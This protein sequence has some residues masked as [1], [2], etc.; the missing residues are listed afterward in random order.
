MFSKLEFSDLYK[1]L[2]SVGLIFIALSLLLPWLVMNQGDTL[3]FS[4]EDYDQLYQK[5]ANL[6]DKRVEFNLLA[7]QWVP[8]ISIV[9]FSLGVLLV[10][11]GIAKW[12]P[13]QRKVDETEAIELAKLQLSMTTLD[14][15]AIHKKAE[16]EV[17]MEIKQSKGNDT[18]EVEVEEVDSLEKVRRVKEPTASYAPK[19]L[20][21]FIKER[22]EQ[23]DKLIEMEQLF[24]NKIIEYNSFNYKPSSNVQINSKY[25]VDI[26]LN[27]HNIRDN[28][29]IIIEIK[30]LQNQLSM[31][32]VRDEAKRLREL[33]GQYFSLTKRRVK[34]AIVIVYKHD[35]ANKDQI[36]RF[37]S[38]ISDFT[39]ELNAAIMQLYVLSDKETEQFDIRSIVQ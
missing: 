21:E 3:A 31:S 25:E 1:F 12:L 5:S 33:H 6:L 10:W 32:T 23:R 38:A 11:L 35:I 27:S 30:Y 29:D 8:L 4:Q 16:K 20:K 28:S 34:I 26:L 18:E 39:N 9:M 37:R 19:S 15:E 14:Q 22:V 13:K 36:N 17:E 24:Y 2:T 7:I